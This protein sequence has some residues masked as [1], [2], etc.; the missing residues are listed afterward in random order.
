MNHILRFL[1]LETL[2]FACTPV[3]WTDDGG[4]FCMQP[5]QAREMCVAG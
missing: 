1:E 2:R 4:V 3:F 5:M